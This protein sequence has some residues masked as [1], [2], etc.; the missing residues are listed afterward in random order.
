M[1]VGGDLRFAGGIAWYEG[2]VSVA[3][4]SGLVVKNKLL[5]TD[6]YDNVLGKW[7]VEDLWTVYQEELL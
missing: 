7:R 5:F 4:V 1:D 2:E 6:V 3:F